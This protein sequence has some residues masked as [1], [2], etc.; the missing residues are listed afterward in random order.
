M[1]QLATWSRDPPFAEAISRVFSSRVWSAQLI[2]TAVLD[3]ILKLLETRQEPEIV[4]DKSATSVSFP[5]NS[6]DKDVLNATTLAQHAR[7]SERGT[8]AL[9]DLPEDRRSASPPEQVLDR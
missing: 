1:S 5:K 2:W 3:T 4:E 8:L 6:A 9:G 7:E